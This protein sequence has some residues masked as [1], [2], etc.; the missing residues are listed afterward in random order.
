MHIPDI[1]SLLTGIASLIS[2]FLSAGERFAN[3]RKYTLP[4]AAT[5]GGFAIGRISPSLSSGM[6]QLFGDPKVAGFILLFFMIIAA[7]ILVACLLMRYGEIRLAYL[8][9]IMGMI[10]VP[11]GIM[12]MYSKILEAA[13]PPGDLIKLAQI[14]V[15]SGEYEQAAKYLES[16]RDQTK[17]DILKKELQT[18]IDAI[19][20]EA[21]KVS[22][23]GQTK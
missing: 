13:I 16:A 15:S 18:Q 22:V 12:P 2:L 9:F 11:M 19:M 14:K 5:L 8:V 4:V 7:M 21:A 23:G 3:W 20:K 10:S 6:D 17:N 1:W